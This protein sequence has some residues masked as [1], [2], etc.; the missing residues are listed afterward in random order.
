MA[1]NLKKKFDPNAMMQDLTSSFLSGNTEDVV[2]I[3]TFTESNWGLRFGIHSPLLPTQKFIL[4]SFYGLPLDDKNRTI[5]VPDIVN[6][7]ILYTFSEK[8]FLHWLYEEGRC[9]TDETDGR[10][11]T[12]LDLVLG[13][14]GTKCRSSDDYLATTAGTIKFR[15][16][17][18]RKARGESIGI[19]TYDPET[20]KQSVTEDFDAWDNGIH[21]CLTVT[22]KRGIKE[23]SSWNHPYLAWRDD[24]HKPKFINL[25]DLKPGDRI[26]V[27]SSVGLFGEGGIGVNRAKLLG[28]FQGDGGTTESVRFTTVCDKQLEEFNSLIQSEFPGYCLRDAGEITYRVAKQSG[29][30]K[31]NGSRRNVVKDWLVDVGCFGKK[32]TRKQV[33]DVIMRGSKEET[34]AFLSRLF[35]CDACA[36]IDS[37]TDDSHSTPKGVIKYSSS[38]EEL[39]NGVRHL[40]L[41]FGIHAV[42]RYTKAK[43]NGKEF[44]H[45][46]VTI[47][48][49]NSTAIFARDI[50]IFSKESRVGLVLSRSQERGKPNGKFWCAPKGLWNHIKM[51]MEFSSRSAIDIAGCGNKR[52]RY[53]YSPSLR[54]VV[55]YGENLDDEFVRSIGS[56]DVLWD[57]VKNVENAGEIPTV[58]LNVRKTHIIGG[59]IVSHNTTLSSIISNYEMYKLVKRGDPSSYFGFPPETAIA[60][61]CV[62]PTDDQ[63][64]NVFETALSRT[65]Q[66]PFLRDRMVN[67]TQTYFNIQ[68][69]ADIASGAKRKRASILC[70]AGGCSSNSLRGRNSILVIMDEVAFFIDNG[71]RFSGTEVY[72]ALTPSTADF[73]GEGKIVCASSPYAKYGVFWDRYNQ[74]FNEE[75]TLMF[76][77][78]TALANNRVPASFLRDERR[79][80]KTAFVCEFGGEFSD[81]V[82]AWVE[83]ENDFRPCV[84][85]SGHHRGVNGI[86]YFMGI[87]LGIKNDGTGVAVVHRDNETKKIILDHA[88]VWYSGSSDVWNNENNIYQ[89]CTKYSGSEYLQMVNIVKEI[90]ELCKEYPIKE[91]WFDQFNGYS[92]MEQLHNKGL[93]QFNMEHVTDTLNCKIYQLLKMLYMD[94]MVELYDHP[95]LIPELLSL[96]AEH[97]SKNRIIVR[98]TNKDGSHDDISDAYARA[99][100]IAF[101]KMA[102]R[103]SNIATVA[104]GRMGG[105]PVR[106]KTGSSR[107]TTSTLHSYQKMRVHGAGGAKSRNVIPKKRV[108]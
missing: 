11:F 12:E 47:S 30:K 102:I 38:S 35:A 81:S 53:E 73:M 26:A 67:Q 41:K 99:V 8:E 29:Y 92:L 93:T 68:T 33:P 86:T 101:N 36:S 46:T 27:S 97:K 61:M 72:K 65:I 87:D 108:R 95:V 6:D 77:M 105:I 5:N 15:E 78:Y 9:N 51:A 24:W 75:R 28:Y 57:E 1:T 106:N 52:L 2:D 76:K 63:A 25:E 13:R 3:I 32:A 54:K 103:Q 37:F 88:D 83:D 55:D 91:G 48:D 98:A 96:E 107:A 71:G 10:Q 94:N 42:L 44:D 84:K 43:L 20:L 50:N 59:D 18:D 89:D 64:S 79:K 31:Q 17:V 21:R 70:I 66:C 45:W 39:A 62:A 14:R 19:I 80:N 34:A 82:V 85:S 23:T 49:K 4:K 60:I 100:W 22:T 104:G 69:D 90:E 7:R 56:S 74:S 16:V 58:D 40:L